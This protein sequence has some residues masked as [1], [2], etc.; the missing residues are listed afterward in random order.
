MGADLG[1]LDPVE[2]QAVP[3]ARGPEGTVAEPGT[4]CQRQIGPG[5]VR[6][7]KGQERRRAFQPTPLQR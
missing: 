5:A 1:I 3:D 2:A 7:G 6:C 4:G